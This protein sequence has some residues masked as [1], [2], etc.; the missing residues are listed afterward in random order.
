MLSN[1]Q[2]VNELYMANSTIADGQSSLY[3]YNINTTSGAA[4]GSNFQNFYFQARLRLF[5]LDHF[6]IRILH[7]DIFQLADR[8]GYIP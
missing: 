8:A 2:S 6:R 1:I 7:G 5:Y 3:V 4:I